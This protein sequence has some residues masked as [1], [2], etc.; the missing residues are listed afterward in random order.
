MPKEIVLSRGYITIVDDADYKH[1]SRWKWSYSQGYAVRKVRTTNGTKSLGMHHQL[2][3][4]AS[5]QL[6]D[7]KNGNRL[8]N[9]KNN[10]RVCKKLHNNMNRRP[11]SGKRASHYKGVHLRKG[12]K[13]NPW[14]ATI[15]HNG[16]NIYLG[17]FPTPE[18]AANAYN[19]AA[20]KLYGEYAW[21]NV[22][23][24]GA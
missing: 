15:G 22:I 12:R 24:R 13:R 2:M 9:R 21:L 16:K 14:Y 11:N 23:K 5:D 17:V 18:A 4:P 19:A 3:N 7:H 6:V 1:L 10:L 8:D 20:L